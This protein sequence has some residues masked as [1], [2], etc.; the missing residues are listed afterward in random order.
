MT[1][2][3]L[4]CALRTQEDVV[5]ARQ[6]ARVVAAELGFSLQDQTRISTAVSEIARNAF[7]YGGGGTVEF[8]LEARSRP[9]QLLI[10]VHDNGPGIKDLAAVLEGAYESTT[11]MG[12][13][14]VGSRR[15]VDDFAIESAAGQGTRV[16]LLKH[17]PEERAIRRDRLTDLAA[18]LA[19]EKPNDP[20]QE[21]RVQN[22]E[23]LANLDELS[24]RQ[25]E[26]QH[27][28]TE[29]N[30]T[31][32]GVVALY[33]ELD[34]KAESLRRASEMKSRFI[35]NVSH[36]LR[37]PIN[38]IMAMSGLLLDRLDGDLTAEQE[39]QIAYIRQSARGLSDL[40]NDLLDIAKIESGKTEVRPEEFAVEPLL[41]ELRGTMRS[42]QHH[43]VELVFD[44]P[45]DMTCRTDRG[46][47]VQVLRNLISNALKFTLHGRVTVTARH[48]SDGLAS[49][50][51]ADTG[52]GIPAEKHDLIFEEFVQVEN[53][54]QAKAKGTGLGL[55]LCR[56]LAHLLGG[57]IGV[58]SA[59]GKGSTFYIVVPATYAEPSTER[60]PRESKPLAT[61]SV[62][63]VDDD[64][65]VAH[66]IAHRLRECGS[67]RI[68][69]YESG[70]EGL[71]AIRA[72]HPDLAIL[73][74]H[75]PDLPGDEILRDLKGDAETR[76]IPVAIVTSAELGEAR[77]RALAPAVGVWSKA[78]LS[79]D[80][81]LAIL[82]AAAHARNAE[83]S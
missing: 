74:L 9:Q 45:S 61:P 1:R 67:G 56:Q 75:I 49:F 46:K 5:H 41:A 32:Q 66:V 58:Q 73:D 40:I 13:G 3:I 55:A 29:L 21:M 8:S 79:R 19:A 27:L 72:L 24:R 63:V 23:I 59:P 18:R 37:T 57:S 76:A 16:R 7:S 42:L 10:D 62:V 20:L 12:L 48:A 71:A 34:D 80:T 38:S 36:E 14:I 53:P 11:G 33:A 51:V 26:L 22:R 82:T 2:R 44:C 77:R 52:I 69:I 70:V 4:V 78:V 28:S 35:S 83:R 25:E 39:R 65:G 17:L 60:T 64:P 43:D 50:A 30:N 54:L 6:V 31:N 47:I 15:L 81:V 68:H